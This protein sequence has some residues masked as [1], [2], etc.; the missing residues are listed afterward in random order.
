MLPPFVKNTAID[1]P[2]ADEAINAAP[3]RPLRVAFVSFGFGEYSVRHANALARYAGVK[4]LL[5]LPRESAGTYAADIDSRVVP[6]LFRHPRYRQ[7]FQQYRLIRQLVRKIADFQ[8]DVIHFQ[9][10]HPWF[11]F[12]LKSFR[13]RALVLT[14]HN[15]RHHIGDVASR[16]TPQWVMDLGYRQAHRIIVHGVKLKQQLVQ[17]LRLSPGS[18]DVIPHIAMGRMPATEMPEDPWMVLFFGRIWQYK[19][20]EYF[21]KCEPL[22]SQRFPSVRFVIAGEGEDFARYRSMMSH[23]EHFEVH[24][25]RVGEEKR[26][27]LFAQAAMVVLP[28]LSATQSGVVPVA[29]QHAKPVI[30]TDVGALSEV[31]LHEENGLLIPPADSAALASAICR[32]LGDPELARRMGRQGR[33]FL[34]AT[35]SDSTVA[36]RHAATYRAA[37]LSQRGVVS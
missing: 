28:Y 19:G 2:F 27:Q 4:V 5:L 12:M 13:R 8:P 23:P 22:V 35:S 26:E 6:Y 18:I 14:V 32:L 3:K 16:K 31:V 1:S 15:P 20:L 7:V 10:G 36:Q 37:I 25:E 21:I 33:A 24:N 9:S 17:E 11:N 29:F 30:A 34:D